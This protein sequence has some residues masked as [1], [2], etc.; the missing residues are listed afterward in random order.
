MTGIEKYFHYCVYSL[1]LMYNLSDYTNIST[2]TKSYIGTG[3]ITYL[4]DLIT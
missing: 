1:P 4:E 3:L 2:D